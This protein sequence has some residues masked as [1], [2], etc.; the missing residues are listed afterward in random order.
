MSEITVGRITFTPGP[1]RARVKRT[2]ESWW[3][4]APKDNGE[5]YLAECVARQDANEANAHLIAAAPDLL[6]S[7]KELREALAGAMRVISTSDQADLTDCF[8]EEME[9]IGIVDGIGIRADTAIQK[10]EQLAGD[11]LHE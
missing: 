10:A 3:V 1:W 2:G 5:G 7:C 9:R 6:A 4:V 8:V 11:T